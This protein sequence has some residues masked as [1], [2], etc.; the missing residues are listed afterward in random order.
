MMLAVA[1][2][3]ILGAYVGQ[4][5]LNEHARN[6]SLAIQDANRVIEQ[7]RQ[8]NSGPGCQ[9]DVC[10]QNNCA[11]NWNDWLAVTGG[12]KSILPDPNVDERIVV[13]CQNSTGTA[14]CPNSQDGTE[15]NTAYG[16]SPVD[17]ILVTVAV[18][19]RHRN[20]T[21]GECIWNGAALQA[22]PTVSVPND[23]PLVIQSPAMLTTLV[24]CRG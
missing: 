23:D 9:V 24:T 8:D 15:W 12:G 20:R 7:I 21:I 1:T 19:W 18:C 5:T 6:L 22:D 10:P 14:Y 2:T 11:T 3:A 13:T 4:V 17:P 16:A